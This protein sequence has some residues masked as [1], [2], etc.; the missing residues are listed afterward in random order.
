MP[1]RMQFKVSEKNMLLTG[2]IGRCRA[3][4]PM[5]EEAHISLLRCLLWTWKVCGWHVAPPLGGEVEW[6]GGRCVPAIIKYFLACWALSKAGN[7]H[8]VENQTDVVPMFMS[9]PS[10]CPWYVCVC[11]C[12]CMCEPTQAHMHAWE[13]ERLFWVKS[14][15]L[16]SGIC[17]N[18]DR[19]FSYHHQT[20]H[21]GIQ[22]CLSSR[23]SPVVGSKRIHLKCR[24]CGFDPWVGKIPWR[25]RW[26]LTP[27]FLAWEIPWT[28][29]PGGLPSMGSQRVGHNWVT[30]Q[31]EQVP[32]W[33]ST[34]AWS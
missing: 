33:Q 32:V 15:W 3:N 34:T 23:N 2:G 4:T 19:P 11:V 8:L 24:K 21:P 6:S 30:K 28:E 25:R 22:F 27:I 10:A 29:E 9:S 13:M 5:Q 17:H 14:Q 20:D 26:Q 7:R 1:I 12:V 31:Q 16:S 18:S